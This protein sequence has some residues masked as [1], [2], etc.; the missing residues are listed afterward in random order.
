MYITGKGTMPGAHLEFGNLSTGEAVLSAWWAA[1]HLLGVGG[2]VSIRYLLPATLSLPQPCPGACVT[3]SEAVDGD[4]LGS[5]PP[6]RSGSQA[7]TKPA[8][9]TQAASWI[10]WQDAGSSCPF[11]PKQGLGQDHL[12]ISG[13]A[14]QQD[15]HHSSFITSPHDSKGKEMIYLKPEPSCWVFKVS[16][17]I[18]CRKLGWQ[19]LSGAVSPLTL[20][21]DYWVRRRFQSRADGFTCMDVSGSPQGSSNKHSSAHVCLPRP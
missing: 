11:C 13:T 3:C 10:L 7:G 2:M 15:L 4:P 20:A 6:A 5:P 16:E 21:N 1:A 9:K 17:C 19:S 8:Q 18:P 12:G 14:Y